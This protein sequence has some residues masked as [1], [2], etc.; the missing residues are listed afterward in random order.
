M[1]MSR[2]AKSD[3]VCVN[4]I[5]DMLIEAHEI[6]K[7]FN[8]SSKNNYS[9]LKNMHDQLHEIFLRKLRLIQTVEGKSEITM[10]LSNLL[11]GDFGPLMHRINQ[12]IMKFKL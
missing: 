9:E 10:A 1:H 4:D 2:Q 7:R 11:D 8:S 12:E 5:M 6:K 3:N